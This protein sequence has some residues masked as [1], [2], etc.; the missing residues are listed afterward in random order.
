M[1]ASRQPRESASYR[2]YGVA[3]PI[4]LDLTP[5]GVRVV[6]RYERKSSGYVVNEVHG[7]RFYKQY[8]SR[9]ELA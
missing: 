5:A 9:V 7:W 1:A 8:D 2:P 6:Y 4:M 3:R